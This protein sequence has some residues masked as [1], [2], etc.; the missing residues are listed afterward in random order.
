MLMTREAI[1]HAASK[2]ESTHDLLVLLN[3]IKM[4]ELGDKGHPFTMPQLNYFINPKRNSSH[5]KTFY[6]PKK[7]GGQREISAPTHILK[8]LQTYM[9]RILQA[10]YEAP[11]YVT[12]F[13]PSKSIVDNAE[14]HIGMRYIFNSDL[15]DFF[16]SIPQ[17]RVWG[18]LQTR[19][20]SFS[21]EIASAIAGLC[22]VEARDEKG[23]LIHVLP[24]GSPCS[25]TLTNIICHNLDWKLNG[26]AKRFHLK[27]SRY[28]DDI[29][30]S[31]DH[32]VYQDDGEFVREFRRI[33]VGQHF[34]L[35][36]KKTRIQKRGERQEVTGLVVS[37]RANVAREYVRDIDNLL[38]IWE[39]HGHNAAFA[40][41]IARYTPKQDLRKGTPDMKSVIMGRLMYLRMVKGEDSPVWRCLQKRFNRLAD[42]KESCGGTNIQYLHAYPIDVFE[43]TVGTDVSFI[44]EDGFVTCSFTLN[45]SVHSVRLGKYA[46]TRIKSILEG[47]SEE[48][49]QKYKE[50]FHIGFCHMEGT[51][52]DYRFWMIFRRPPKAKGLEITDVDEILSLTDFVGLPESGETDSGDSLTTDAVLEALIS[53]DFDLNTLD[54]WDKIKSS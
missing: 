28:A 11:E 29:T 34:K 15:K 1:V 16:P 27:Y 46:K 42:K 14:R 6:I 12:G 30:F 5:Y 35:N 21:K 33:V 4:D 2:L 22:C 54:K 51:S 24:Q 10:F 45:G 19:P 40:K 20:F 7:S 48:A 32:Y 41:F 38:Y 26:L 36:E 50:R 53:S 23:K 3:R 9:N 17:A 47:G 25:P 52:E 39:K 44:L 31:S 43:K 37:D 18:A 8:S 49:M 13:V